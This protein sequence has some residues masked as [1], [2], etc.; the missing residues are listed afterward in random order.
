MSL[1]DFNAL[2]CNGCTFAFDA[3]RV[4]PIPTRAVVMLPSANGRPSGFQPE[5]DSSTLSGSNADMLSI[6][7]HLR[8]LMVT[9]YQQGKM[10]YLV[11][12]AG[13]IGLP[14]FLSSP[15]S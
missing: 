4:G 12:Q 10:F 6:R 9:Y 14:S 13:L 11:H 5:N 1:F 3:N 7:G 8:A 15:D 2:K